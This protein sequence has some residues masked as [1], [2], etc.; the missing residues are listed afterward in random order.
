MG[1]NTTKPA[2]LG[3]RQ[4]PFASIA[5]TFVPHDVPHRSW[6]ALWDRSC[7]D[8]GLFQPPSVLVDHEAIAA[9]KAGVIGLARSGAAR[10]I[11]FGHHTSWHTTAVPHPNTPR[12]G[13]GPTLGVARRDSHVGAART[14][15]EHVAVRAA[16]GCCSAVG[17]SA[18]CGRPYPSGHQPGRL[19]YVAGHHGPVRH[20]SSG[21][22]IGPVPSTRG[23]LPCR[24]ANDGAGSGRFGSGLVERARG[25]VGAIVGGRTGICQPPVLVRPT[26]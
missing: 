16:V 18:R 22:R 3:E 24:L 8:P 7:V 21:G 12:R 23:A 25:H 6:F 11:T 4:N 15:R 20:R 10:S 14:P 13:N 9:A 2:T 17:S 5:L 19:R 26:H 1:D